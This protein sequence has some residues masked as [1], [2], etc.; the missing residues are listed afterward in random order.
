MNTSQLPCA[1]QIGD[2][3]SVVFPP[4]ELLNC[5]IEGIK[6]KTNGAVYYDLSVSIKRPEL[7][8]FQFAK[9]T[10]I[11]WA[12]VCKQGEENHARTLDLAFENEKC[13]PPSNGDFRSLTRFE[14]QATLHKMDFYKLDN[15]FIA[16][17]WGGELIFFE[18]APLFCHKPITREEIIKMIDES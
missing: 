5:K 1:H 15:G 6:F 17:V 3:V 14:L 9:L 12:F 4:Q 13:L 18:T 2:Y 10:D 7:P 8:K 11:H 16:P